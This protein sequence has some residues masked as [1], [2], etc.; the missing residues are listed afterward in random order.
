MKVIIE[1][2]LIKTVLE[3]AKKV[4]PKEILFLLRG[5]KKGKEI[6]VR[7]LILPPKVIFGEGFASFSHYDLPID[8]SIV[9]SIHSHP[10]PSNKP[11]TE[12]L[13]NMYG[14]FMIIVRYPFDDLEDLKAYD[15]EGRELELEII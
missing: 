15:R 6:R 10:S 3:A 12:D 7:E 1:E 2:R 13:N 11:S 5:K 4:Y 8:L 14:L 9:G